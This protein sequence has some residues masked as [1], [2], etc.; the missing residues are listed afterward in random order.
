MTKTFPEL[1]LDRPVVASAGLRLS[2]AADLGFLGF[3]DTYHATFEGNVSWLPYDKVLLAYEFRQK[4]DPYGTI[5]NGVGGYLVGGEDNW[6]AFDLALIPN[7]HSTIVA[8]WG[9]F[10]NLANT[11]ADNSWFF[12]Y[13]YEF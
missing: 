9:I 2:E 11:K 1:L 3:G 12:Q 5:P 7:K 6:H 13:K 10:G 8:G 4:T